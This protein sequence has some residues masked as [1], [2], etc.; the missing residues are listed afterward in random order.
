MMNETDKK[1]AIINCFKQMIANWSCLNASP[2]MNVLTLNCLDSEYEKIIAEAYKDYIRYESP[3][4]YYFAI[5][6]NYI[7]LPKNDT[8]SDK[9]DNVKRN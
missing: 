3:V 1:N 7:N 6:G 9:Y 8:D 4:C 2:T 5:G